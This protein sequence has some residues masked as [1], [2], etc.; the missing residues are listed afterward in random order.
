M[1]LDR[2]VVKMTLE[3]AQLLSSA[4]IM[5]GGKA[6]YKAAYKGHPCTVWTSKSREN[7]L[8]LVA[9]GKALAEEYTFRYE[10]RHKSLDVIEEV[11]KS[12]HVVPSLGL[13]PFA[14][15]M[16]DKYKNPS[17]PVSSY[18]AYYLGEKTGFA[19]WTKRPPPDWWKVC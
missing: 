19:K 4:V 11:E 6:P 15:A 12:A 3:T 10:K 7:F 18:R 1:Q 5:N 13:L 16:P 17:D 8:W 2:H 14:L 9:H